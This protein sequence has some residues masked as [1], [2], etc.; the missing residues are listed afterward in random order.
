MEKMVD[1]TKGVQSTLWMQDLSTK[2]QNQ[3][4]Q[5]F[6]QRYVNR[7]MI[8]TRDGVSK[9]YSPPRK[10]KRREQARLTELQKFEAEKLKIRL[11]AKEK[12]AKSYTKGELKLIRAIEK[13]RLAVVDRAIEALEENGECNEILS[14]RMN[15]PASARSSSQLNDWKTEGGNVIVPS[16]SPVRSRRALSAYN[17]V[18]QSKFLRF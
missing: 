10:T 9:I 8:I 4:R 6:V 12:I 18:I 7:S 15:Q 5:P 14:E 17:K 13:A 1:S 11:I 3:C 16:G 2:T